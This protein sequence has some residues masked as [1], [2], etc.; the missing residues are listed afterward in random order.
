MH[1]TFIKYIEE[2]NADFSLLQSVE[3][4]EEAGENMYTFGVS[5]ELLQEWGIDSVAAFLTEVSNLYAALCKSQML[6]YSWFDEMASQIRLSAISIQH[7]KLPFGCDIE[8]CELEQLVAG[9][10]AGNSGLFIEPN[11]LLVWQK[12]I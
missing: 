1:L 4:S 7:G 3:V 9:I 6:F 10:F 8:L 11:K 12:Q 5:E 2:L